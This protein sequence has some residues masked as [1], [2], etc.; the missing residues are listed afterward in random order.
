[1]DRFRKE[2]KLMNNAW[3]QDPRLKSMNPEKI[4]LLSDFT[5]QL[6]KTPK[7]QMLVKF[8]ALSAEANNRNISFSD[9]ETS[10]LA[11]ILINYVNPAERNK[12]DMLRMLSKKLA[13]KGGS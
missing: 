8:F 7:D 10:L 3:K 9:Q 11:E 1:M 12:I 13:S 6:N 4:Q 5:E 2:L